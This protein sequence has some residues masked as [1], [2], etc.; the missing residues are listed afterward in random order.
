MLPIT[1]GGGDANKNVEY[2]YVGCPS[3][4]N[5][6][7]AKNKYQ[8]S[9]PKPGI[10]SFRKLYPLTNNS[11]GQFSNEFVFTKA[12]IFFISTPLSTNNQIKIHMSNGYRTGDVSDGGLTEY[13]I[14]C[15]KN[16]NI[17][18]AEAK[19][20]IVGTNAPVFWPINTN[21]PTE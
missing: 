16:N 11:F 18:H 17:L 8:L 5:F 6:S 9:T 21:V 1:P 10:S 3:N 19:T 15:D 14:F 4:T 12:G 2:V 7:S 20:D 13:T